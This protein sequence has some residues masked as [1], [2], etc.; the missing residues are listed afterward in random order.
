MLVEGTFI[1]I[2]LTFLSIRKLPSNNMNCKEGV[3]VAR[4]WK[5]RTYT[6]Q[7]KSSTL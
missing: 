4:E 6:W 5:R 7:K 1:K 3:Y 2:Q